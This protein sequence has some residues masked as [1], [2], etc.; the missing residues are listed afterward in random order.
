MGNMKI[1]VVQEYRIHDY[2]TIW[3]DTHAYRFESNALKK[4]QEIKEQ[5]M[6]PIVEE[7]S[8]E[9]HCDTPRHFE[10]GRVEDCYSK[11]SVCVKITE[12]VVEDYI[13]SE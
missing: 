8:F 10:A 13:L 6:M 2:E 5:D 9:V 4:L 7:E 1:Y 3:H 11:D 12:T